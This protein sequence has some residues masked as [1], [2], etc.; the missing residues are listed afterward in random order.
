MVKDTPVRD[1]ATTVE[2]VSMT[3][4]HNDGYNITIHGDDFIAAGS[5]QGLDSLN[6][7][8]ENNFRTKSMGIIGPNCSQMSGKFL[9]R[10]A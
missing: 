2:A 7:T 8:M 9:R 6:H 5:R 3:C 10:T 4:M 1:G